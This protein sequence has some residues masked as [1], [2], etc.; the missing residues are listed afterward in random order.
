MLNL[1]VLKD[2]I[3][4]MYRTLNILKQHIVMI[5]EGFMHLHIGGE[6]TVT[7]F[8]FFFFLSVVHETTGNV[9]TLT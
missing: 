2:L 5:R 9:I 6:I 8:F 7:S 1:L 4:K 3:E